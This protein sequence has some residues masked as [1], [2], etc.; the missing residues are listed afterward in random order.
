MTLRPAC[1]ECFD[2][3]VS[4]IGLILGLLAVASRTLIVHDAIALAVASAVSMGAGE[5]LSDRAG[6]IRLATTM[7]VATLVGTLAP[8]LPFLVFSKPQAVVGAGVLM[9]CFAIWIA[10]MRS[11]TEPRLRSY[12]VTFSILA[13]AIGVTLLVTLAFNA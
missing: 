2:G 11:R 3:M 7:A 12:V 10:Q 9:T 5:Y 4:V 13:A 1:S 8:I 6:G